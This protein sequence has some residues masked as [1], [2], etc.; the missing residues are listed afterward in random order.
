MHWKI[1]LSIVQLF[2]PVIKCKKHR[3]SSWTQSKLMTASLSAPTFR[4][5]PRLPVSQML[6]RNP[7][8]W[9]YPS[10]DPSPEG[11]CGWCARRSLHQQRIP[12]QLKV[13]GNFG[14]CNQV[15]VPRSL[16]GAEGLPPARKL[17]RRRNRGAAGLGWAE[18]G[19]KAG[20]SAPSHFS[21]QWHPFPSCTIQI[22]QQG[23]GMSASQQL[24]GWESAK[25]HWVPTSRFQVRKWEVERWGEVRQLGWRLPG[26]ERR[27]ATQTLVWA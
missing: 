19:Y 12:Q 8:L 16:K 13:G 1:N 20:L 10:P 18:M 3:S 6:T 14:A 17:G 15:S 4:I 22:L 23:E 11:A 9:V 5:T 21:C 24:L 26:S 2:Q 27:M 25:G 7:S